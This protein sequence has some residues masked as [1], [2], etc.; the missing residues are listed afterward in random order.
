MLKQGYVRW[1]ALFWSTCGITKG[2][3]L[4]FELHTPL[5]FC[6]PLKV[7]WLDCMLKLIATEIGIRKLIQ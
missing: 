7:K 3:I 1:H 6:T 2:V 4:G 5:G